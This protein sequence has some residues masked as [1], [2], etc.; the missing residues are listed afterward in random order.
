MEPDDDGDYGIVHDGMLC[1]V[2]ILGGEEPIVRVW[3]QAAYDVKRSAK[4][5][6]E[7]NEVN[8]GL[9]LLRCFWH[10]GTVIVAGEMVLESVEPGDLGGLVMHVGATARHT[11]ELVAAFFGG[12][13]AAAP[14]CDSESEHEQ[15]GE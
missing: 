14:Q 5:L 11:G 12:E 2:R 10:Q 4:L 1:W 9:R 8:S 3:A 15:A 6:A 7:L 13:V